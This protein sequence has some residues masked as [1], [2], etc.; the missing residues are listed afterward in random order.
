L[1]ITIFRAVASGFGKDAP[2]NEIPGAKSWRSARC[3]W[4]FTVAK[5]FSHRLFWRVFFLCQGC[6]LIK[7][8]ASLIFIGARSL[9]TVAPKESNATVLFSLYCPGLC[10]GG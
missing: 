7:L 1:G 6:Q 9:A 2:D 4:L 10:R 3:R 5:P 8:G